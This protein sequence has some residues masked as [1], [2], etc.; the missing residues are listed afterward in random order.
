V[1]GRR[2]LLLLP[3]L[4]ALSCHAATPV[5]TGAEMLLRDHLE[6]LRGRRI[7]LITN[8]TGALPSG[9]YLVDSLLALG[10]RVT[11]LF[12]PEHGI[13]GT[14]PAG[15]M[16]HDTLDPR[17][18][19]PVFSLYGGTQRPSPTML[20]D[21]DVLVYDLQDTG[22]RFFTYISTMKFA[23]EAA[24]ERRLPFVV[25]D[26][27]NPLGGLTMDGPVMEDSLR[28]FV[29]SLPVPVVYGLTCGELAEMINGEGW[30]AGG[31]RAALTVV[32]ME[33][34]RR[35][36][37]W[38]DTGLQWIRPSPNMVSPQTA[39]L[40]PGCCLV[41]ATNLSEGRGTEEP[42][43][44]IGA[45]FVDSTRLFREISTVPHPGVSITPAVFTPGASKFA[46]KECR[47]IRLA[48]TDAAAVDPVVMGV[49]I[50]GAF[51]RAHPEAVTIDGKM[52]GRLTGSQRTVDGVI[53]GRD[54][55]LMREEWQPRLREFRAKASKYA[56]YPE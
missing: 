20:R 45:P 24:A 49:G 54:P 34:W 17:T 2:A 47:G 15:T 51:R 52:M 55:A 44:L 16:I 36:L 18:G 22:A 33:G 27:P 1:I 37:R 10:I 50:V 8:Q 28:S 53:S 31:A 43:Q 39:M 14:T 3:A 56:I 11:A 41:E 6:L 4:V 5:R 29:G 46:G 32:R 35:S 42:F 9:T 23:M 12:S 19:I 25:L 38:E 26:R 40:Y 13:R 21:V 7:G 48:V 30:L